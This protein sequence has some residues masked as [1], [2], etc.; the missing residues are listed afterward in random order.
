M[1]ESLPVASVLC[2]FLCDSH[3]LQFQY[4]S[5]SPSHS[6]YLSLSLLPSVGFP[7][8]FQSWRSFFHSS[9]PLSFLNYFF[10]RFLKSWSTLFH[11]SILLSPFSWFSPGSFN[12]G[13]LSSIT[14]SYSAFL[15]LL[16][17]RL[18]ISIFS[19]PCLH[20]TLSSFI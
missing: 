13:H 17:F 12:F 2:I 18:L 4:N 7:H 9:I 15:Q 3:P 16:F 19:L 10:S 20:L 5:I 8:L 11:P 14:P 6:L 1:Y